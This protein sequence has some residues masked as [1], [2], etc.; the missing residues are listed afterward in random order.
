LGK[1]G[2]SVF[3]EEE[4]KKIRT[5]VQEKY[6]KVSSSADG[7]FRYQTGKAGAAMLGYDEDILTQVPGD[8]LDSFCGVGNP[9]SLGE[10]AEGAGI[11]D[12][13]CGAGFDLIVARKKAGP[14]GRVCGVDLTREMVARAQSN[15]AGLAMEDI[16]TLHIDSEKLPFADRSFDLLISNGAINLSPDKAELFQEMYRVLKPG[17]RLQ[18]ADMVLDKELPPSMAADLD[19]WAQ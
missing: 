10:I 4:K 11:L 15:F 1:D 14:Q 5:A 7:L 2:K 3:T 19:A 12:I 6:I 16:E 8:V 17:G 18:I 13:G 9:F